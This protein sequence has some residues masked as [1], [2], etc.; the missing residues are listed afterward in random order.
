VDF[1]VITLRD[2]QILVD[3]G[4]FK[5]GETISTQALRDKGIVSKTSEGVKLLVKGELKTKL[6]LDIERASANAKA[7]IEKLGGSV[8][9][10]VK[11]AKRE[12]VKKDPKTGKA[13]KA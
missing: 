7:A 12:K 11:Q 6:S 2:L 8:T 13:I 9:V 10:K 4:T 1:D 5:A 3:N